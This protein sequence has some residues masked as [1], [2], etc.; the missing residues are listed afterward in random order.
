MDLSP[1]FSPRSL[2]TIVTEKYSA[3]FGDDDDLQE[4]L[5][6]EEEIGGEY[7]ECMYRIFEKKWFVTRCLQP[8]RIHHDKM[9][10]SP[11]TRNDVS[12]LRLCVTLS[13]RSGWVKDWL[14]ATSESP[15]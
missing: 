7:C 4:T 9:T 13:E 1:G 10:V 15:E 2:E 14:T 11:Y 6:E 3:E 8:L 12:L 5:P